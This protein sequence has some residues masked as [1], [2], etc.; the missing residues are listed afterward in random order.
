MTP[1]ETVIASLREYAANTASNAAMYRKSFPGNELAEARA[2]KS[3]EMSL[4]WEYL[5]EYASAVLPDLTA[6]TERA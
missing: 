1:A 6:I 4:L 2:A 3:D 5:A